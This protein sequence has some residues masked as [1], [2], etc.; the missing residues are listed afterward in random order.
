MKTSKLNVP[1]TSVDLSHVLPHRIIRERHLRFQLAIKYHLV[2]PGMGRNKAACVEVAFHL[3]LLMP[4]PRFEL[5]C[6]EDITAIHPEGKIPQ[7]DAG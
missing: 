4:I 7:L 2:C 5:E 6:A 1:Q 3:N